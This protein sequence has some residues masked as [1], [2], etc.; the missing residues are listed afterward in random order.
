[1]MKDLKNAAIRSSG[2]L[3]QDALGAISLMVMLFGGLYLPMLT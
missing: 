3:F 2:T 1:M